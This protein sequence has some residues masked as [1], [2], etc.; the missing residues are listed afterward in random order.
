M[1]RPPVSESPEVKLVFY[2]GKMTE[3]INPGRALSKM[4]S[5]KTYVCQVCGVTFEARGAAK[6]HNNACKQKAKRR[7]YRKEKL[8]TVEEMVRVCDCRAGIDRDDACN[9]L[10]SYQFKKRLD[11]LERYKTG[12][13]NL[14]ELERIFKEK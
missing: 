11:A 7:R 13:I 6:Y 8:E 4:R 3:Q 12:F 14:H 1:G 2:G 10:T 5:L 9:L